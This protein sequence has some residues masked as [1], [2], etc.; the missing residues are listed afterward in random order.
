VPVVSAARRYG[1][2]TSSGLVNVSSAVPKVMS[3]E[4]ATENRNQPPVGSSCTHRWPRNAGRSS[5]G[6]VSGNGFIWGVDGIA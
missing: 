4:S 1:A 3:P 2:G 6:G 5:S